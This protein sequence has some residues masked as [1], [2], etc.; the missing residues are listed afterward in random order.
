MQL[1]KDYS[2]ICRYIILLLASSQILHSGTTSRSSLRTLSIP[3]ES[4]ESRTHS[5][6]VEAFH[7][8]AHAARFMSF[9]HSEPS[10]PRD[11]TP[12]EASP[13]RLRGGYRT[14][15]VLR[16]YILVSSKS[17]PCDGDGS[18]LRSAALAQPPDPSALHRYGVFLMDRLGNTTGA[19]AMF[20]YAER[21]A[22]TP[23]RRP[24]PPPPSRPPALPIPSL[25][26]PTTPSPPPRA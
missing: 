8:Y 24:A 25:P 17:D 21:S 19:E 2:A 22:R 15:D 18:A 16:R 11:T 7:A 26:A 23:P 4:T 1:R 10:P 9:Q 12:A 3:F 13:L 20:R 5:I 6:S 14:S